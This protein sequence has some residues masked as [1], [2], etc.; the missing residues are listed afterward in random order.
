MS[1]DDLIRRGDVERLLRSLDVH[2]EGERS[3]R[4]YAVGLVREMIP[5]D[6][7]SAAA[8]RLAEATDAEMEAQDAYVRAFGDEEI[9]KAWVL[10]SAARKAKAEALA[11]WRSLAREPKTWPDPVTAFA[12]VR[13]A[14]PDAF[15][16]VA[17]CAICDG[18]PANDCACVCPNGGAPE[19]CQE[20]GCHEGRVKRTDVFTGELLFV[21]CPRCAKGGG[22]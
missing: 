22:A 11:A 18:G 12:A 9:G 21:P 10:F 6:P 19:R 2:G 15:E 17:I 16:G 4:D 14:V 5:S 7:R 13:A 8:V 20:P 3:L 1:A